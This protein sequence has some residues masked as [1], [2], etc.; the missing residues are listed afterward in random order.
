MAKE[1]Q[2]KSI[3]F[4]MSFFFVISCGGGE[5]WFV[6]GGELGDCTDRSGKYL[7]SY[8]KTYDAYGTCPYIQDKVL[9][10]NEDVPFGC[11]AWQ[12]VSPN[13]CNTAVKLDCGVYVYDGLKCVL[14]GCYFN[15][16]QEHRVVWNDSGTQGRG[17]LD[18]YITD[19]LDTLSC[20]GAYKTKIEEF[21]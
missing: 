3:I 8:E 9:T 10:V 15:V 6:P 14:D 11:V 7:V 20:R 19:A 2:M 5:D 16:N 4:I 18:I 12:W 21:Y 1:M 13:N 17:E